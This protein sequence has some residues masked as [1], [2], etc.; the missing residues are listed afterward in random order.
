[1]NGPKILHYGPIPNE[2]QFVNS[3]YAYSDDLLDYT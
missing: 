2:N 3:E 1:M